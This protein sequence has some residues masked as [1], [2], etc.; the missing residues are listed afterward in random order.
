MNIYEMLTDDVQILDREDVLDLP[1]ASLIDEV[2][3]F[4]YE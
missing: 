2:F 3:F 4:L 1:T